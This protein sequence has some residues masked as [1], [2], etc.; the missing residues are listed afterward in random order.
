MLILRPQ[1]LQK[2]S[3]SNSYKYHNE[4]FK[5]QKKLKLWMTNI[6]NL[7]LVN[8]IVPSSSRVWTSVQ[9]DMDDVCSHKNLHMTVPMLEPFMVKGEETKIYINQACWKH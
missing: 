9:L 3:T 8:G 2:G 6:S 7:M 4:G 5:V 1:A